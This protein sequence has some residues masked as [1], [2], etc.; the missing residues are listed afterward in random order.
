MGRQR[1][2]GKFNTQGPVHVHSHVY[3]RI[4]QSFKKNLLYKQQ[5]HAHL[6]LERV[7][8]AVSAWLTRFLEGRN[9][10]SFRVANSSSS[11]S[12]GM[13]RI[14]NQSDHHSSKSILLRAAAAATTAVD[15]SAAIAG[16]GASAS[17][18]ASAMELR[19]SISRR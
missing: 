4:F 14:V 2:T 11:S 7:Y 9:A 12:S 19:I 5:K 10:Y 3:V 13:I 17:A 16:A 18:S 6:K 15:R 1:V 8:S